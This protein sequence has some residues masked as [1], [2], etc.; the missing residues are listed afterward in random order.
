MRACCASFDQQSGVDGKGGSGGPPHL[1]DGGH[2]S[3][4]PVGQWARLAT[5]LVLANAFAA[6]AGLMKQLPPVP[7]AVALHCSRL[8]Y[9]HRMP[10]SS[11][12]A[13]QTGYVCA[14]AGAARL[15]MHA[16]ARSAAMAIGIRRISSLHQ[17]VAVRIERVLDAHRDGDR[18]AGRFIPAGPRAACVAALAE[19]Q[20]PVTCD[21]DFE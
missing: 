2:C 11:A 15:K 21:D 9:S 6:D 19:V 10:S 14:L 7:D 8:V 17:S 1:L 16:E 4:A 20:D 3:R 13:R 5:R 18:M 12:A